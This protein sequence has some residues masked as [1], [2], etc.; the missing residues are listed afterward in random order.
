MIIQALLVSGLVLC[1]SYGIVQRQKS[2]L[3][4]NAILVVS[5]TGIYFV[6]FPERTSQ[7]AHWVGVGRGADLVLYCW[8]VISIIFSMHLQLQILHL[9]ALITDLAREIALQG[10]RRSATE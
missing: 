8:L 6:L 10:S 1:L 4:S 9:H 5:L 3:L 7:L 2:R